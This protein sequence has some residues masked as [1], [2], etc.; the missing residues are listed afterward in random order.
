MSAETHAPR[1]TLFDRF[2]TALAVNALPMKADFEEL[3]RVYAAG[4][5]VAEKVG[6]TYL[7]ALIKGA[8]V[9][10]GRKPE[11]GESKALNVAHAEYLPCIVRG[12]TTPDVAPIAGP[13]GDSPNVVRAENKRRALERNRRSNFA[14]TAASAVRGYLGAGGKLADIP[15]PTVTK[16]WLVSEAARMRGPIAAAHIALGVADDILPPTTGRVQIRAMKH[17][18]ALIADLAQLCH[19]GCATDAESLAAYVTSHVSVFVDPSA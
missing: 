5:I 14:R 4:G 6:T 11:D 17:A 7:R 1:A 8:L 10:H 18:R 9:T 15:L 13:A 19:N 2:A 16:S 12:I 3:G